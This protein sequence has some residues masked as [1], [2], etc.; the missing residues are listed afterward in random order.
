MSTST[1]IDRVIKGFYCTCIISNDCRLQSH[2][3]QWLCCSVT[4][5]MYPNCIYRAWLRNTSQRRHMSAVVCHITGIS[6]ISIIC[7]GLPH[8]NITRFGLFVGRIHEC[9]SHP[10]GTI[11]PNTF[12]CHDIGMKFSHTEGTAGRKEDTTVHKAA[13]TWIKRFRTCRESPKSLNGN[14][15]MI[16]KGIG[17]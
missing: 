6:I 13:Y 12:P 7:R 10:K 9:K 14:L 17:P 8:M 1:E 15:Y 11:M 16:F 3:R 4:N 5:P 2:P